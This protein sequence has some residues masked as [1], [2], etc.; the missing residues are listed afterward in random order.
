MT[1]TAM[2]TAEEVTNGRL[3]GGRSSAADES[4]S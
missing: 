1:I 3:R 2:R 4:I